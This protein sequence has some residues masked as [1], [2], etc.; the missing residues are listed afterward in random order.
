[1]AAASD[2]KSGSLS[3]VPRHGDTATDQLMRHVRGLLHRR[4]VK[5]SGD[6]DRGQIP[7]RDVPDPLRPRFYLIGGFGPDYPTG[8]KRV[9]PPCC[10]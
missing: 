3:S 10:D 4:P 9:L 5:D 8:G 6:A 7:D 2:A 1:M